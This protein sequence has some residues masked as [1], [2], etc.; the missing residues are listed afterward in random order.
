MISLLL[1]ASL[2]AAPAISQGDARAELIGG[3]RSELAD[4]A[5]DVV[6][7]DAQG[8][9][10]E[11]WKGW[12]RAGG[13]VPK[14][15]LAEIREACARR[16]C[17]GT[18]ARRVLYARRVKGA[19]KPASV[20]GW[21][22]SL[23]WIVGGE[24]FALGPAAGPGAPDVF[25]PGAEA[26][27]KSECRHRRPKIEHRYAVQAIV[28]V[29]EPKLHYLAVI[30]G[31]TLKDGDTTAKGAHVVRIRPE[32]VELLEDGKPLFVPAPEHAKRPNR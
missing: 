27:L 29:T 16:P 20:H 22:V 4:Q 14:E 11:V 17:A 18:H 6:A 26:K 3:F 15:V 7:I 31:E 9:I 24:A 10:V 1:A 21:H 5:T 8:K 23:A 12:L 19:W 32:G 25:S 28:G 2:G 30:D 13:K